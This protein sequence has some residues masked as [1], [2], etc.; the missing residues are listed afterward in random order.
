MSTDDTQIPGSVDGELVEASTAAKLAAPFLALGAA[1]AVRKAME[2]VYV[3][4]TGTRPPNAGDPDASMRRVIIW[5]ASTAAA[6]AIINVAI[7]RMTAPTR[8]TD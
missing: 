4:S 5:A 1:W 6:I 3:R 2:A 7:D 8:V